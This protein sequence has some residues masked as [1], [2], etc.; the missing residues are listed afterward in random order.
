LHYVYFRSRAWSRFW[1]PAVQRWSP[2]LSTTGTSARLPWAVSQ[3]EPDF[4]TGN[5]SST[6][7]VS[8]NTGSA[9]LLKSGL[10]LN[11]CYGEFH[12]LKKRKLYSAS[13]DKVKNVVL[14][15]H[16]ECPEGVIL[17]QDAVGK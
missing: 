14:S 11:C 2:E 10:T 12:C 6:N 13:S 16:L 4:S 5:V 3:S 7:S 17:L 1:K 8:L 15:L 9:R